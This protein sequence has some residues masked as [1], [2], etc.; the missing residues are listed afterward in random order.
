[1]LY[2]YVQMGFISRPLKNWFFNNVVHTSPKTVT[3]YPKWTTRVVGETKK[4]LA[5]A[6]YIHQEYFWDDIPE[7]S[8]LKNEESFLWYKVEQAFCKWEILTTNRLAE[9]KKVLKNFL[10]ILEKWMRMEEE[11]GIFFDMY[12][13]NGVV[14]NASELPKA[15]P[16]LVF[17]NFIMSPDK[18]IKYIDVWYLLLS[19]PLVR[20]SKIVRELITDCFV[21]KW[22][23]TPLAIR[24]RQSIL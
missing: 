8:I 23:N 22:K 14:V 21:R 5:T 10:K 24:F 7:T 11:T 1:M 20:S 3:K 4:K 6:L 13:R 2:P 19:N 12:W 15:N 17:S 9:D 18:S 16:N